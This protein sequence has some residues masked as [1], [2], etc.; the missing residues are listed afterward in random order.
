MSN[1]PTDDALIAELNALGAGAKMMGLTAKDPTRSDPSVQPVTPKNPAAKPLG[2]DP[3]DPALEPAPALTDLL[4][5]K[6]EPSAPKPGQ[7]TLNADK[8]HSKASGGFGFRV[9]VKGEYYAK[10]IETKGNVTKHYEIPFNL[11]ALT[12]SKGESALGI[13]IGASRPG[14][15]MLKAALHKLDSLA[16]TFRTHE[17]VSVV[18][19]NGAPPPTSLLYM[20]FDALKAYVRGNLPDFPVDVDEYNSIEHLREDVIDFK[21]NQVGEVIFEPGTLSESK[22]KGGFGLK[23]TP[24][25]RI[26]ARHA[27]RKENAELAAMNEGV[28]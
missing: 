12:N 23:K 8:T 14:G 22:L 7:R 10:A 27:E 16:I 26:L 25:D 21:T 18:P 13:I 11:P 17:I 5:T 2:L 4:E 1:E 24:T 15:G 9:T 6:V 3:R 20:S 19:L 28:L